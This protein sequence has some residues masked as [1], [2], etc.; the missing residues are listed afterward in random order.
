MQ[1]PSQQSFD[2]EY[3]D[4]IKIRELID[5]YSRYADRREAKKQ[6]ALFASDAIVEVYQGRLQTKKPVQVIQ[7]RAHLETA[8]DVLNQYEI[9]THFNGQSL[10]SIE[11]DRA[12]GETYCLAHH[13]WTEQ[14]KRILMTM[15]IRYQ[16]EFIRLNEVWLIAMRKIVIDWVDSQPSTH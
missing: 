10:L 3:S 12:S 2:R 1:D 16:D 14:G 13:L 4:R 5:N 7:G 15:S 8:L 9:T 6:A 11:G